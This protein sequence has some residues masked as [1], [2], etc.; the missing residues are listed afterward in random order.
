MAILVPSIFNA[1]LAGM[2]AGFQSGRKSTDSTAADYL[3]QKNAA[4]VFATALDTSVGADATLAAA[5][6]T[7]VPGSA[8]QANAAE[9]R[10]LLMMSL[11][12][13]YFEGATISGDATVDTNPLTYTTSIA[14][15]KAQYTEALVGYSN[16]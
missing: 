11:C 12:K 13:A 1:A 6:A 3:A 14:S 10:P 15:I 4:V 9:T 16:A 8:A 5:G 2:M 7:L